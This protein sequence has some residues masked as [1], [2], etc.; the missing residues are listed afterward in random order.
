MCICMACPVPNDLTP[1]GDV[2]RGSEWRLKF[3]Y[4][5]HNPSRR[6]VVRLR[7]TSKALRALLT[8]A[9]R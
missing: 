4:A 7:I 6:I 8:I 5:P 3:V 1:V 2:A 9:G